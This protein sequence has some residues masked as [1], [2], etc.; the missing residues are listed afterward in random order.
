MSHVERWT[1]G[2]VAAVAL[3]GAGVITRS[4]T[5]LVG[6]AIPVVYVVSGWLTTVE[7]SPAELRVEREME[8]SSVFPGDRVAVTLRVT[9]V[10]DRPLADLRVADGVPEEVAVVEGSPRGGCSL[11][12]G[13]TATFEYVA[14]A[15][16]GTHE[17][18]PV[19]VR[20]RSL[21][22]T[23]VET[24]A[25]T[26]DGEGA[27]T[28]RPDLE[29]VPLQRRTQQ[30]AGT[31]RTE[32]GG[33]GVEFHSTREY[34]PGDPVSRI[35]W[36]RLAKT[37][38]LTTVNYREHRSARVVL[39]VD[40]REPCHVA[41]DAGTPTGAAMSAYGATL[42]LEALLGAG[43]AVGAAAFGVTDRTR[44]GG[45]AWIR[46][47]SGDE[48]RLRTEE[49]FET[50]AEPPHRR[51]PRDYAAPGPRQRRPARGSDPTHG[52]RGTAP[53]ATDGGDDP[54]RTLCGRLSPEAQVL[55]F[56]PALDEFPERAVRRI[57]AYGHQ[58]TVVS[59]DVTGDDSTGA[60]LSRVE[61]AIRLERLREA[62]ARVVDWQRDRPLAIALAKALEGI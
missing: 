55:L 13:E 19:R 45:P 20:A 8:R 18:D 36:R 7:L 9:N 3:A 61:R 14:A 28:C 37:G 41:P 53:R 25:V 4:P 46:P 29:E 59:P 35:D 42:A 44:S 57:T 43:H 31:V 33:S 30:F 12:P 58:V 54:V 10:G 32:T 11:Q 47:G 15:R 62:G 1:G 52:P 6:A 48:L 23:D 26:P 17:F 27:L 24:V 56:T 5:L 39:A 34:R 49:L 60:R 21:T 16:R 40:A 2:L 51:A 50:A 22:A 38:D